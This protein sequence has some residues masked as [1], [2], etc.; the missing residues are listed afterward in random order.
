MHDIIAHKDV[1]VIGL[2]QETSLPVCA[3]HKNE[4]ICPA[5]GAENELRNR[6]KRARSSQSPVPGPGGK[7]GKLKVHGASG[8]I[9]TTRG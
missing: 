9:R 5:G 2:N 4:E 8:W 7:A 6:Q 1:R 3:V